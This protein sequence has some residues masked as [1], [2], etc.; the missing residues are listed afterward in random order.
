MQA[1]ANH[2]QYII[3]MP[4]MRTYLKEDVTPEAINEMKLAIQDVQQHYPIDTTRIYLHANCSGGY[5]ALQIATGNPDMFA[6]IG[7]YAPDYQRS[8][9]EKPTRTHAPHLQIERLK[10]IPLFIH[11]DPLDGHSTYDAFADLINDSKR[12]GIP[13]TLSVKRNSGQFYNVVLV[14]EEA[15]DFFRDKHRTD[16]H[17]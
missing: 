4:E 12:V 8:T 2:Y 3:M 6:A 5:R 9:E 16:N 1:W 10:G 17:E 15:L 13:L 14:G 7:L 11:Y